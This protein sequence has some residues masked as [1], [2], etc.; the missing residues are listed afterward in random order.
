VDKY[1]VKMYKVHEC[2]DRWHF[3]GEKPDYFWVKK[4]AKWGYSILEITMECIRMHNEEQKMQLRRDLKWHAGLSIE[5]VKI[6][7]TEGGKEG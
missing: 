1:E 6:T 3:T 4:L 5:A 2:L 7:I